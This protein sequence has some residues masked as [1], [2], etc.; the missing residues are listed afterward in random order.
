MEK[1]EFFWD[2]RDKA[3]LEFVY[4]D[5]KYKFKTKKDLQEYINKM[6]SREA[7]KKINAKN[8]PYRD[9]YYARNKEMRT[10]YRYIWANKPE[11][12]VREKIRNAPHRI[13]KAKK[14]NFNDILRCTKSQFKLYIESQFKEGMSWDNYKTV[15]VFDHIIPICQIDPN[16]EYSIL[17]IGNYTNVQPIFKSENWKKS[18]KIDGVTRERSRVAR[19]IEDLRAEVAKIKLERAK[20]KEIEKIQKVFMKNLKKIEK[21]NKVNKTD[22]RAAYMREYRRLKKKQQEQK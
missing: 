6:S 1:K 17:K 21:Q 22:D 11:N 9:E 16:D 3:I 5:K 20:Q 4:D 18:D 10:L 15:W 7:V 19:K 14:D 8:K 2:M 12:L 13:L